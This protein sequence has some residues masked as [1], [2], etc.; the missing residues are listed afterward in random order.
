M[1]PRAL[2]CGIGHHLGDGVDRSA[3]DTGGR[4]DLGDLR[5][6]VLRGPRADDLVEFVLV[7][8]AP[9]GST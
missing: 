7:L 4:E 6:R 5:G 9:D 3:D 8:A 2:R 1:A